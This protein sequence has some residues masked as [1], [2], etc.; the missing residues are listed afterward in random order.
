[1]HLAKKINKQNEIKY[2]KEGDAK[3]EANFWS[4]KSGSLFSKPQLG[5]LPP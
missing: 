4:E 1:M 2:K 5:F 3:G